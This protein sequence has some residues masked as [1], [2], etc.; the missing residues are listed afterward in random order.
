VIETGQFYAAQDQPAGSHL[1]LPWRGRVRYIVPR[2]AAGQVACWRLFQ[3]GRIELPL[4]AIARLPQIFGAIRCVESDSLAVIRKATG[5][6]VGLTFCRLGAPGPWTKETILFLDQAGDPELIVKAGKGEA[7]D[8]LLLNEAEWLRL[9]RDQP[10][11]VGHIPE[12]VAHRSGA[13][14]SFVAQS[15]LPG[16]PSFEFGELHRAFL[17]KFQAYSHGLLHYEESRLYHNLHA[18]IKE[19][20]GLL[21][22]AWSGRIERAMRSLEECFSGVPILMTAAHNDFTPWNI[23][24]QGGAAKVFD[25]EYAE[26]EQ[27]PLFDPLHFALMPMALKRESAASMIEKMRQTLKEC[28]SWLGPDLCRAAEK[29]AL[30]YLL[31]L[32]TLYLWSLRGSYDADPVLESYE[33]IIDYLCYI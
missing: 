33:R 31:N 5:K 4:R 15:V 9:L 1:A 28:E 26:L 17:I 24:I 32:S 18:R 14:L 3:P 10:A 22:Q 12:M 25:W 30:A 2:A 7:V 29:Q 19:L 27:L 21:S 13:D 8:R 23:R 20:D 11:L 16:Q 6:N